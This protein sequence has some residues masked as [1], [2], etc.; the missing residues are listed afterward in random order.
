MDIQES[1]HKVEDTFSA[2]IEKG[3][4]CSFKKEEEANMNIN[5]V[6]KQRSN[7]LLSTNPSS[8]LQSQSV[9]EQAELQC[10]ERLKENNVCS[11][12]MIND[13]SLQDILDLTFEKFIDPVE[14]QEL[15][16]ASPWNE[17]LDFNPSL[18]DKSLETIHSLL[19]N[20]G[21]IY[22]SKQDYPR[23]IDS[24]EKSKSIAL[25]IL[26][27]STRNTLPLALS[28]KAIGDIYEKQSRYEVALQ[29][30]TAAVPY[31]TKSDQHT[32]QL[33]GYTYKNIAF[34]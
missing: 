27:N 4:K 7:I 5:R 9:Y 29:Y 13:W 34:V 20:N 24:Y 22:E 10:D 19:L 6:N 18:E 31:Y 11:K 1:S 23:A 25:S 17:L 32:F 12:A 21:Q 33:L 3:N 14:I 28:L 8:S 15:K 16:S 26:T 30:Y 2:Q